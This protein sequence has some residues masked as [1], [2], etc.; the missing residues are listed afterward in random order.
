MPPPQQPPE[1]L[2]LLFGELHTMKLLS[3]FWQQASPVVMHPHCVLQNAPEPLQLGGKFPPQPLGIVAVWQ[4]GSELQQRSLLQL[5]LQFLG[6]HD[7]PHSFVTVPVSRHDGQLVLQH[8]PPTHDLPQTVLQ[9][10][11]H[12]FVEVA[13]WHDGH[14]SLQQTSLKQ[15]RPPVQLVPVH[16][17]PE[18]L[19][20]HAGVVPAH[21]LAQQMPPTQWPFVHSWSPFVVEHDPPLAF[22]RRHALPSQ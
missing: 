22:F 15:L 7:W 20:L 4:L 3:G 5:V 12:A 21:V 6:P 1:P 9:A 10:C 14:E 19:A 8:T 16:A 11:P 13:V 18:P 17:H 2:Q